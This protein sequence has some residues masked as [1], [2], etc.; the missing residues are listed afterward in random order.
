[1]SGFGPFAAIL[2]PLA[3]AGA[4]YLGMEQRQPCCLIAEDQALIGMALEAYLEDVGIAVAGPFAS[5]A[6]A[7]SWVERKTPDIAILDF[8]LKDG[9]CTELARVLIG[10]G[11]PLVIYSGCRRN[12]E[13]PAEL[14]DVVWLEKPIDRATLLDVVRQLVHP[15]A[16]PASEPALQ[17]LQ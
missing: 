17:C 12:A 14:R 3:R 10:R 15:T 1:L 4:R 11:V 6:A 16:T 7:L 8:K 5:C 9:P 2:F 13:A